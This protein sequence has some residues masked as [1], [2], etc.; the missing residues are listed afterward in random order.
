MWEWVSAAPQCPLKGQRALLPSTLN[1]STPCLDVCCAGCTSSPSCRAGCGAC[2]AVHHLPCTPA[3]D[4][5]V[6]AYTGIA[7][8][9]N[10]EMR[11]E[12]QGKPVAGCCAGVLTVVLCIWLLSELCGKQGM[13]AG[14]QQHGA[15]GD[16]DVDT[17]SMGTAP[18]T[19]LHASLCGT[20]ALALT[21]QQACPTQTPRGPGHASSDQKHLLGRAGR[22]TGAGVA[23]LLLGL[24]QP[25]RVLPRMLCAPW[26]GQPLQDMALE[27]MKCVMTRNGGQGRAGWCTVQ[28]GDTSSATQERKGHQRVAWEPKAPALVREK[29]LSKQRSVLCD[30]WERPHSRPRSCSCFI[31]P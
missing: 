22:S 10:R 20:E 17:W 27:W 11:M 1:P 8:W 26:G 15:T 13:A 2:T 30:R 31:F 9:N 18:G 12:E 3:G 28:S 23:V 4:P 5:M 14:V 29:K 6:Q 21:V 16:R 25:P 24:K 19:L 7:W